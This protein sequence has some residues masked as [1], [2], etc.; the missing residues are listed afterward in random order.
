MTTLTEL[1][2]GKRAVAE[3]A[4]ST[5]VPSAGAWVMPFSNAVMQ[6]RI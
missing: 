3:A 2:P 6:S 5:Q 4:F 1:V